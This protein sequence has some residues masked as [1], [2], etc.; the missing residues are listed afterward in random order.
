MGDL[1]LLVGVGA[2]V[3]IQVGRE[4]Y[5]RSKEVGALR[6]QIA[7]CSVRPQSTIQGGRVQIQGRAVPVLVSTAPLCGR[8][9]I[10]LRVKIEKEA[11][12]AANNGIGA[13]NWA[14]GPVLEAMHIAEASNTHARGAD[15][16]SSKSATSG[17]AR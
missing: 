1:I 2:F 6:H 13:P 3:A 7:A 8:P 14:W 15:G 11:L 4:L 10:G 16:C 12:E 5:R 17:C 9:V